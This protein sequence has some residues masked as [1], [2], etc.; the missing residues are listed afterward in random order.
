MEKDLEKQ[1]KELERFKYEVKKE[2]ISWPIT[3]PVHEEPKQ[4]K[5]KK[6]LFHK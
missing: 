6:K 1:K 2:T 4:Q 3:C 5:V